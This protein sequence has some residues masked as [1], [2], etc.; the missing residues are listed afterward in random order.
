M[1]VAPS[2]PAEESPSGTSWPVAAIVY[3]DDA[4]PGALFRA[5]VDRWRAAG[6]TVAGV[7]QH[8]VFETADAR[9]NVLLE[10]LASGHQTALFE[11]R[12]SGAAGCRLDQAA[13]AEATA[14]VEGSLARAPDI[15]VLNKFGKAE[16]QGG[17][18]R[19]LV[20]GAIGRGIPVVIGV[21]RQTLE[22]WRDFADGLAIELPADFDAVERWRQRLR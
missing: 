14:R 18:L 13:L 19:D 1:S 10:D 4:Y 8:Q 12:G 5:L 16:C 22:V 17:G 6:L 20:A 11:N 2:D 7:V 15:L 3:P 9:C 21:P